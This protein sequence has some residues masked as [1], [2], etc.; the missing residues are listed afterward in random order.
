MSD[1]SIAQA[2]FST[3]LEQAR[4]ATKNIFDS[5]G[6]SSK[7]PATGA[8]TTGA[9][10]SAFDP[11]KVVQQDA[12]GVITTNQDYLNSLSTTGFG[13]GFGYNQMS[14]AMEQGA[15]NEAAV[16]ANYRG[17]GLGGG[18][19]MNQARTAAESEQTRGQS[20]VAASLIEKLG[21]VYGNVATSA[22]GYM[23]SMMDA[24]SAA[25]VTDSTTLGGITGNAPTT[26]PVAPSSDTFPANPHQNQRWHN[27]AGVQYQYLGGKWKL[28]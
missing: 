13:T 11:S 24:A 10:G 4:G 26:P 14:S 15:G 20:G 23:G 19:L 5:F 21:Q 12:N 18:G 17:R 2:A 27:A 22:S 6:V 16:A 1:A 8:W 7:D 25:G 28:V 3:A 9:A